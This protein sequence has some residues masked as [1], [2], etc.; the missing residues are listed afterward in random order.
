MSMA[1][2][3]I[4]NSP[5]SPPWLWIW[6]V[7]YLM[8]MPAIASWPGR[9]ELTEPQLSSNEVAGSDEDAFLNHL[10]KLAE[11]HRNG[12]RWS[13]RVV[14]RGFVICL[15]LAIYAPLLGIT[16]FLMP[17]TRCR[18]I[19]QK[20]SLKS[21]AHYQAI[22]SLADIQAFVD[23]RAPGVEVYANPAR[24][25]QTPFCY[26]S[27]F[28]STRI[29]VFGNTI[30]LWC[31]D[32]TAAESM[33]L[34]ELSHAQHGDALLVGP[35]GLLQRTFRLMAWA[36]GLMLCVP[37]LVMLAIML[38]L[39]LIS[40]YQGE[41]LLALLGAVF[42]AFMLL[43]GV[44]IAVAIWFGLLFIFP[45]FWLSLIAAVWSAEVSADF[46]ALQ[47]SSNPEGLLN[48][49]KR[50]AGKRRL[51]NRY[52]SLFTH[53]PRWLRLR[54]A[55]NPGAA[56]AFMLTLFPLS[57]FFMR[58]MFGLVTFMGDLAF[59][60]SSFSFS[61]ASF[62]AFD[63]F[64]TRAG[65]LLICGLLCLLWPSMVESWKKFW[66]PTDTL[67]HTLNDSPSSRSAIHLKVG[68]AWSCLGA[69]GVIIAPERAARGLIDFGM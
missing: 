54:L 14:T 50:D 34:H 48:A 20:Y 32:R 26:P 63:L 18:R 45:I 56:M 57:F 25:G 31:S 12:L 59:Q 11:A 13:H 41:W 62:E 30:M 43:A 9:I 22:S 55:K 16:V 58:I 66:N 39:I 7:L 68:A 5:G 42:L 17:R 3:R 19:E 10:E 8:Q 69:L 24:T 64:T 23:S 40:M 33:L 61:A 29:A 2:D 44:G 37:N 51:W 36:S 28:R 4:G 53:P 1:H 52:L 67:T 27:G 46:H 15:F 49:L 60:E 65:R 21:G 6:I 38:Y 47:G 35:A